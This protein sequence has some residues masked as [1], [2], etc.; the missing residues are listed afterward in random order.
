MEI[1]STKA[2]ISMLLSCRLQVPI[3]ICSKCERG[4]KVQNLELA[5]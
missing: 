2:E 3:R 4:E 1:S 5:E